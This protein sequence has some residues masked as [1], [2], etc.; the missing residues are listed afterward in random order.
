VIENF[1]QYLLI[2]TADN[3]CPHQLLYYIVCSHVIWELKIQK[4]KNQK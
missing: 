3:N 4:Y 1:V 2:R